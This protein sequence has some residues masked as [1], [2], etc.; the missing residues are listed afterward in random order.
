MFLKFLALTVLFFSDCFGDE[1]DES[2]HCNQL[3]DAFG[4]KNAV[5]V[6]CVLDNNEHAIFCE[7]CISPYVEMLA[8]F[9]KLMSENETSHN[10]R[11]CRSRFVDI[12]QL[13]LLETIFGYSKRLWEIGDCSGEI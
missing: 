9:N 6:K 1:V 7:D 8:A 5:F 4:N 2:Q 12:N 3:N 11:P 10:G 13:D